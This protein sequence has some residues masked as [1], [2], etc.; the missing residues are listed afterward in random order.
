MF[1]FVSII[2]IEH[3]EMSTTCPL[4]YERTKTLIGILRFLDP[5]YWQFYGQTNSNLFSVHTFRLH[6]VGHMIFIF[7]FVNIHTLC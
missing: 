5:V 6:T 3:K 7:I 1:V 2:E 4:L